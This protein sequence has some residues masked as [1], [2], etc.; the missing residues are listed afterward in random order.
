LPALT[1]TENTTGSPTSNPAELAIVIRSV[2]ATVA[3]AVC[4]T[5]TGVHAV[6]NV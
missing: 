1:D 6:I 3:V 2:D 5:V 4:V